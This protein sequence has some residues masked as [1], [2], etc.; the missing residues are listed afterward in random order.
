MNLLEGSVDFRNVVQNSAGIGE[1]VLARGDSGHPRDIDT[2]DTVRV[3]VISQQRHVKHALKPFSKHP[4]FPLCCT[5]QEGFATTG[6]S[7]R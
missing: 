7:P 2:R 4:P 5:D 6:V 3:P 1:G